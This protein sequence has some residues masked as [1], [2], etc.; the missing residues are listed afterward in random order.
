[1]HIFFN[2]YIFEIARVRPPEGVEISKWVSE[3][4]GEELDWNAAYR[5]DD[6][7]GFE[8]HAWET[9]TSDDRV[10]IKAWYDGD[11]EED[12]D[13]EPEFDLDSQ[14]HDMEVRFRQPADAMAF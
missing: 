12:P 2:G 10:S 14:P 1:M 8:Q 6:Y 4:V 5:R 3:L 13:F 9:Q 11:S 7:D